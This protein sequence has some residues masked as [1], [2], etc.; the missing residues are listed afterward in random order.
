MENNLLL[1]IFLFECVTYILYPMRFK[2]NQANIQ[3]F[4]DFNS[5]INIITPPYIA[6]LGFKVQTTNIQVQK[7][8]GSIFKI[9]KMV[10]FS[11]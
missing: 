2:N 3:V 6:R 5:N 7:I 10:L 4:L 11:L 9:F 1:N 8:D